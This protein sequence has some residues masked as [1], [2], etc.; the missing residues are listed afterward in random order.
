MGSGVAAAAAM[1][2]LRTATRT[3]SRLGLPRPT[4]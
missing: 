3:L 1:G 4:S 2:Q